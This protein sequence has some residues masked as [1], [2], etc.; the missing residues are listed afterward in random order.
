[1][2][3]DMTK[4]GQSQIQSV[5]AGRKT[6]DDGRD[7]SSIVYCLSSKAGTELQ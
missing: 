3:L 6:I 2:T 5:L 1:M 4:Y 7:T